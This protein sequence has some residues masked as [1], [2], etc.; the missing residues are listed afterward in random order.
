MK[1]VV[2]FLVVGLLGIGVGAAAV[3]TWHPRY[4]EPAAAV[5]PPRL[6][7]APA[8]TAST[9][10]APAPPALLSGADW[11]AQAPSPEQVIY[12]QAALMQQAIARLTPRTPGKVNLYAVVFAGDGS[13]N[14]FRNEAEYV[15]RLLSRRFAAAGHV[16]VLENNPASLTTRPL[17]TWSNLETALGAIARKMDPA[18]DILLV[19]LTTHGSEDHTLLVDMDPL[20][21]DQIGAPDLADILAEHP[22]HYRVVIVNACYSGGFI[23]ALRSAGTLVITA[24]R[25]DRSSFGCG[26]QSRLTWFG[27]AFI[28][29]ALNRTADFQQAFGMA[30]TEIA[31][32]ERRDHYAASDPQWWAGAGIESQLRKWRE[33]FVPGPALPFSPAPPAPDPAR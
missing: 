27:H 7:A 13:E 21:L 4:A 23:P 33:G 18:Q 17:A 1:R 15:D 8:A 5:P 30:R 22:F 9:A 3:A 24:A 6:V 26:E 10:D 32:W 25:S 2:T 11:P 12:A 16:L 28:V 31:G 20:P 14:V 19:Y 29:N